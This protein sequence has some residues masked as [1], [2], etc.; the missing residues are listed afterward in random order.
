MKQ[1]ETI[2]QYV[3]TLITHTGRQNVI[4]AS[5]TELGFLAYVFVLAKL[6]RHT[7]VAELWLTLLN[8]IYKLI[9]NFF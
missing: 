8:I 4:R 5:V 2:W 3:C 6:W 1:I 7:H 9:I